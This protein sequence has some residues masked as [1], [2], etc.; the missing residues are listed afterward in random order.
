M[1]VKKTKQSTVFSVALKAF[2]PPAF[3]HLLDFLSHS[4]PTL[5]LRG[6][7]VILNILTYHANT[8][9]QP[10][11]LSSYLLQDISFYNSVMREPSL[12]WIFKGLP[13]SHAHQD[14]YIMAPWA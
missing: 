9:G 8:L 2:P 11:V 4:I 5:L 12:S 13:C 3:I 7:K 6:G 14:L 10:Y 1:D